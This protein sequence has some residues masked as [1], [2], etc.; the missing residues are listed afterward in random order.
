MMEAVVAEVREHWPDLRPGAPVPERLQVAKLSLEPYPHPASALLFLVFTNLE[1][2]PVAAAKVA[3][4][5]AGDA[6]IETE[7]RALRAVLARGVE[8]VPTLLA[9]GRWNG[10]AYFLASAVGGRVELHH[11]WGASA[12]AACGARIGAALEWSAA[13]AIGEP[14]SM[15]TATWLGVDSPSAALKKLSEWGAGPELLRRV[16][17]RLPRLWKHTWRAA[18]GHGD[19]FSGNVLFE[20]DRITGVV[21]WLLA[22]DSMPYLHDALC[23]EFSFAMH[24]LATWP[25]R[26]AQELRAVHASAPFTAFRARRD[27]ADIDLSLGSDARLLTLLGNVLRGGAESVGRERVRRRWAQVL[28]LELRISDAEKNP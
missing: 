17:A 10:R 8:S 26:A 18:P 15:D 24:A 22:S 23:Y 13:H 21:D 7:A 5:E 1:C 4:V 12:I 2:E 3:R 25:E 9:S 6:A 20:G 28:D 16:E 19:Y 11:T 14:S 27:H